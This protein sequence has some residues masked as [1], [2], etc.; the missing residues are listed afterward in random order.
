MRH[1]KIFC[2]FLVW[3]LALTVV[4][5][6]GAQIL[7]RGVLGNGGVMLSDSSYHIVGTLGQ[8]F[9]GVTKDA[10][11]VNKIGFW[12]LPTQLISTNVE[13]AENALPKT[14][15]LEQNYPNPFNPTTTIQFALPRSSK[16]T[17]TLFDILGRQVAILVDDELEAGEH[18][19]LFEPKNLATGVYIYRIQAEGFVQA[20]KLMLLK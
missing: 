2:T 11:T 4:Q 17:V 6:A 10:A 12:Y 18:K 15:R 1:I 14:F 19:V 20:R 5:N 3:A 16:V 7:A 8:P 9:I 13:Q